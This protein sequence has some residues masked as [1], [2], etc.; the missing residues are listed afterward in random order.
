MNRAYHVILA[1]C[2]LLIP[3]PVSADDRFEHAPI[4]YSKSSPDNAVTRL[5][6]ELEKGAIKWTRK[7]HTGYLQPLLEALDVKPD[8]QTLVFSKTSLQGKL[9]SPRRPRALYFNDQIYVGYVAGSHLMEV[10]IADP[11]MG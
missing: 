7:K 11:E 8:S 5:G 6:H 3:D 9:I 2:A 10:S 4:N 1:A